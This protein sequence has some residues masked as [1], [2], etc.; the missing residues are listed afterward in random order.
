LKRLRLSA[1]HWVLLTCTAVLAVIA[2]EYYARANRPEHGPYVSPFAPAFKVGDAPP[3][4]ELPDAK[5]KVH[6]LS[7]L[8]KGTTVLAFA[9]GSRNSRGL[10]KYL[11]MLSAHVGDRAPRIVTVASFDPADEPAFRRET[12]TKQ[13]ILYEGAERPISRQYRAERAPRVFHLSF[14]PRVAFIGPSAGE[15]SVYNLGVAA[16]NQFNLSS[17]FAEE[18][19]NRAPEPKHLDRTMP[20][21]QQQASAG[22]H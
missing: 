18:A 8:A 3:E 11:G 1:N 15:D 2:V 20:E 22:S 9:D 19:R 21:L 12:G 10:V 17:P 14:G 5:G 4:F 7:Q 13:V 16:A 6:R